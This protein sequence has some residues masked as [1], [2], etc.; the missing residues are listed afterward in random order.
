MT[1]LYT[2]IEQLYRE[3]QK[4][5]IVFVGAGISVPEPTRLPL[6]KELIESFLRLDWVDDDSKSMLPL[7]KESINRLLDYNLRFEYFLSTFMEWKRHSLSLLLG[8]LADASPN[9]YHKRIACLCKEKIIK[10][11]IT[12]NFDCCFEKALTN[13]DLKYNIIVTEKDNYIKNFDIINIFKIHGSIEKNGSGYL[14]KGLNATLESLS[15]GL[16]FWK[17]ELLKLLLVAL[18]F[19]C[20]H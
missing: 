8:Q 1:G 15:Q 3:S 13:E 4:P 10:D 19:R 12:T 20:L 6:N 2:N 17:N 5:I 9:P 7:D 11:I 18:Q 14:E 16:E